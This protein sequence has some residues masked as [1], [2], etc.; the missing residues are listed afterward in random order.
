MKPCEF[1][2]K[3]IIPA[4]DE[5]GW[6]MRDAELFIPE[7]LIAA[8]S[9]RAATE[10]LRLLRP[11]VETIKLAGTVVLGTAKGDLH[12]IGKN[13]VAITIENAG[14]YI[15]DLGVDVSPQKIA[16][17][18]KQ[19]NA[20]LVALSALLTT[21]MVNMQT[22]GEAPVA[23]SLRNEVKDLS[24]RSSRHR[25]VGALD[26]CRWLGKDAPSAVELARSLAS[27]ASPVKMR[28]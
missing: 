2:P 24:R 22:V 5:V 12:D 13:I 21:T 1:F 16:E 7:V 6:R 11:G 3:A 20:N 8:R 4:M 15:V 23:A 27:A 17:L 25:R 26:R 14:F 28:R 18:V 19:H 10:I 9:A